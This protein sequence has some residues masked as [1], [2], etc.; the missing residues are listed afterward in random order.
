MT[1]HI[2]IVNDPV[3]LVPLLITFNNSDFKK[4][5]G[6]ISKNWMTD[7]EL[8]EEVEIE[9]VRECIAILKKGNLVEEQWR[10]PEPGKKPSKEYKTTYSRFRANFQCTM[11]DLGDLI[12][13]SISTDEVLR[14]LVDEIDKSVHSGNGSVNDLARKFSVSPIFVKGLA[15]RVPHLE[16]KGQGL[17]SLESKGE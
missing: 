13:V 9:K 15:K 4:V 6:L 3:D 7:E 5:Y 12:N 16:V 1:G 11:D 17:V 10:M 2:R 14:D 8:S